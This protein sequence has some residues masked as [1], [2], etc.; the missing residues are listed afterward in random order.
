LNP[1]LTSFNFA[2][3]WSDV[4]IFAEGDDVYEKESPK[5][6]A[7]V[8]EGVTR[9][10]FSNIYVASNIPA[11]LLRA[12]SAT[13]NMVSIRI[14]DLQ[15]HGRPNESNADPQVAV[16]ID[17]AESR[18]RI[19]GLVMSVSRDSATME[20]LR[21]VGDGTLNYPEIHLRASTG[22]NI[23][24]TG[25][26]TLLGGDIR[27]ENPQAVIDLRSCRYVSGVI[28]TPNPQGVGLPKAPDSNHVR[29]ENT[30]R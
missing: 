29:I 22:G 19:D 14:T 23:R 16:V 24:A 5:Y 4:V 28:H 17:V 27:V 21:I 11:L 1:Q 7:I 6:A 26:C 12:S 25:G 15:Q 8:L 18:D 9:A 13:G 20:T 10:T 2:R 3:S 30:G